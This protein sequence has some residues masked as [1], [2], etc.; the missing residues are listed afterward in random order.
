MQKTLLKK[1]AHL[2]ATRGVNVQKNQP[3][4]VSTPVYCYDFVRLLT[5]ELYKQK[6]S[7]VYID[8]QDPYIHKLKINY[9]SKRKLA[10]LPE[11]RIS[12]AKYRFDQN[13][14]RISITSPDFDSAEGMN[15]EKARLYQQAQEAL[16][17]YNRD[18]FMASL[19]Q[20]CVVAVPNEKWAKKVFPEYGS[21]QAIEQ[22]WKAIL[23][24]VHV[25]KENDPV[26]AW[27]KHDAMLKEKSQLLNEFQ[28]DRLHCVSANGTN[29][30]IGL[31]KNHIWI[32]GADGGE[33]GIPVFDANMPT[34]EVFTMPHKERVNGKVIATKPVLYQ[35]TLIE[36][37]YL[38]FQNGKV[39]EA[40]AKKGQEALDAL[41][42]TDEGSKSLGEV[43]LVPYHSPIS[44]SN[45]LF[46]NT[47]FDENASCHLALGNAYVTNM[48]DGIL[49]DKDELARRGCNQSINHVDFM[50]GTNDMKIIGIKE[51]GQQIIV[52]ENGDYA[53]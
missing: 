39:V 21:H 49:L 40:K 11:Y 28:F 29:L 25:T 47:L 1:Y 18:P 52:F 44:L 17:R 46:Y 8:Y 23:Q 20:W 37:F 41:L 35:G 36:D 53:I 31:V 45:I 12:Q 9:E 15:L 34:E 43:A 48:V 16:A 26:Q 50:F 38:I 10:E 13:A 14:C 3:V 7:Q 5:K 33:D 2:I 27:K 24:A 19:R 22:L 30:E 4:I 42:L 32:G 6:A 51:D